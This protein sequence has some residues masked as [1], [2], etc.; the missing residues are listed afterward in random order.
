MMPF[1]NL[2]QESIRYRRLAMIGA[3]LEVGGERNSCIERAD[4]FES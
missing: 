2:Y 4:Q 1:F 3:L